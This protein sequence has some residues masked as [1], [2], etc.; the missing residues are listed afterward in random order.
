MDMNKTYAVFGLGRYGRAVASELSKGGAEVVA[1]DIDEE[2]VND[3]ADE[4]PFSKCADVT[5]E[6]VLKQLGVRNFDIVIVAMSGNLE[7]SVMTTMLLKQ[8]GVPTVIVK[9]ADEMQKKILSKIGADRVVLPE[10]E[11]GTRLAK[12]LLSS[13]FIDVIELSK[14][15]SMVEMEVKNN[16]IGKSLIELNLRKKYSINVVA[17]RKKDS[18]IVDID[19]KIPLDDEMKL[20]VVANPE[21]IRN[22]K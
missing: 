2:A 5:D 20:I 3:V 16:W 22:I 10:T 1:V 15:V 6:N 11:S 17:I 8:A 18:V 12:N 21:K 9:C 4:I 14:D 7:G 13:G 19:P